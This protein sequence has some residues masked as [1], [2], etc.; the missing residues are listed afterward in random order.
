MIK[1]IFSHH[2]IYKTLFKGCKNKVNK[3][4]LNITES[5]LN[6]QRNTKTQINQYY[7][8]RSFCIR[9]RKCFA[10][11]YLHEELFAQTEITTKNGRPTIFQLIL[12][13]DNPLST[14]FSFFLTRQHY[15]FQENCQTTF[16]QGS[17]YN[18]LREYSSLVAWL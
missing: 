17:P 12:Y 3:L 2:C 9:V 13:I 11:L 18:Q 6:A 16:F 5:I 10:A 8:D 4:I 14:E 1:Q 15:Q 7:I